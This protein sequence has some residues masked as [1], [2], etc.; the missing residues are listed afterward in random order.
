LQNAVAFVLK[1]FLDTF[2]ASIDHEMN[3]DSGH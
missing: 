3:P 2:G 1:P